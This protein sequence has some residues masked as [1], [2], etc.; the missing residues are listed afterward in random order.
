MKGWSRQEASTY[1]SLHLKGEA[2]HY[3]EQLSE[4]VKEDLE[5]ARKAMERRFGQKAATEAEKAAFHN[6]FQ[7]EKEP[8]KEFADRV[9]KTAQKAFPGLPT[10]YVDV[11]MVNRFLKGILA[12]DAGLY[13]LNNR[14]ENL[15]KAIEAVQVSVEN[16]SAFGQMKIGAVE[17]LGSSQEEDIARVRFQETGTHSGALYHSPHCPSI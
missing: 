1:L 12:K 6:L 2:L 5:L 4:R 14:Y 15:E 8:L 7:N 17:D 16:R 10:A 11:E 13:A 3:F 9:R